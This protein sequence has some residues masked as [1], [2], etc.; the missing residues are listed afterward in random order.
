VALEGVGT[1]GDGAPECDI[2][3]VS[4]D[5]AACFWIESRFPARI[6]ETRP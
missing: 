6:E 5:I 4:V 1:A 2:E 3:K